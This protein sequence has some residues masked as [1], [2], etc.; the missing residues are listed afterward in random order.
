M[1]LLPTISIQIPTYN[2]AA[3]IAEA[4]DSVLQQVYQN[5]EVIIADDKSK[6]DTQKVIEK[7][8]GDKR[9]KYF[10]NANNLGRIGNYQQSL[11]NYC[12][13]QWAVNL[14][15]DDYFYDKN[16]L[17]DATELILKNP[18]EHVVVFQANHN[19]E[20]I[21]TIFKNCKVL[22]K[23][24]VLIDGK[25]YFINFYKV[26]RFTHCATMFNR[27]EALKLNFYSFDCLFTDLNSIAKLLLTGKIIISGKTVACWRQ[28]NDN[29]S[30]GLNEKNIEQEFLS[31]EDMAAFATPYFT[32]TQLQHWQK[33]MKAYMIT[34]Y[35][36][37]LIYR[38]I[39]A[40][41]F[42]YIIGN[43]SFNMIY[44]KQVFKYFFY[45]K[46]QAS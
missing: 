16:F 4:V 26:Q 17:S 8:T 20:K 14:D 24:A 41:S 45:K 22:N 18:E 3:Y 9:V 6:D 21:K 40:K 25:D 11:Y 32:T 29:Q 27:Q 42:K 36:E 28:H 30:G 1:E 35:I 19:L 33:K 39:S 7:Y 2:Q 23:D 34:T 13:S 38:P 5:T 37:L 43:F 46:K 44:L 15:G 31:I 10:K 12:T